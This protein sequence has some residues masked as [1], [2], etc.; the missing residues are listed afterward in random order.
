MAFSALLRKGKASRRWISISLA[1]NWLF[2][3]FP[4]INGSGFEVLILRS[5]GVP[6]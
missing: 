3:S 5:S 4:Y 1:H 6:L 2:S